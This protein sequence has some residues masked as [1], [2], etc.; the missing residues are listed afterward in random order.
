MAESI[1]KTDEIRLLN[2]QVLMTDGTLSSNVVFPSKKLINH[3]VFTNRNQITSV[4]EGFFTT[5]D[6]TITAKSGNSCFKYTMTSIYGEGNN[7]HSASYRIY[8]QINSP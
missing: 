3:S 2:N 4:G 1:L 7:N 8:V 6:T 5:F